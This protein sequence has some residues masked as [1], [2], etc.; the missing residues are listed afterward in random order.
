[1]VS[2]TRRQ[3]R[4][5]SPPAFNLP[6]LGVPVEDDVGLLDWDVLV[7]SLELDLLTILLALFGGKEGQDALDLSVVLNA[8]DDGSVV[9]SGKIISGSVLDLDRAH[10]GGGG[11]SR[12]GGHEE[13]LA[14]ESGES[15]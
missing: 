5:F 11:R 2:E 12:R 4:A 1:M 8:P 14:L 15:N 13:L 3:E 7:T 10:R 9:R 6:L